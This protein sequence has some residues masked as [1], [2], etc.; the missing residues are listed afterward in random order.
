[1]W[2][3][4][5]V[6]RRWLRV[7]GL[8]SRCI[9]GPEST[10]PHSTDYWVWCPNVLG[11]VWKLWGKQCSIKGLTLRQQMFFYPLFGMWHLI[12]PCSVF[13]LDNLDTVMTHQSNLFGSAVSVLSRLVPT[14]RRK[15][16]LNKRRLYMDFYLP[17]KYKD[18]EPRYMCERIAYSLS[19]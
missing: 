3:N 10:A 14:E 6:W 5:N 15:N 9:V 17:I 2:F 8:K 16:E 11:P 19:Q 13:D 1:M 4:K 7:P 18:Y 12:C